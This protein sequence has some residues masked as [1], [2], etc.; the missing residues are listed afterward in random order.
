MVLTAWFR[1][2]RTNIDGPLAVGAVGRR[3]EVGETVKLVPQ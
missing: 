2:T 1:R 3:I